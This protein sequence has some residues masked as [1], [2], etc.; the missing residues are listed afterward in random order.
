MTDIRGHQKILQ[1]FLHAIQTN[2]KPI[3]DG[4]EGRKSVALIEAIYRA[5]RSASATVSL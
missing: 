3:C 2:S 4:T 1:D 5:S